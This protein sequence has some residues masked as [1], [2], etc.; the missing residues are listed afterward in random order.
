MLSGF[1]SSKAS[2]ASTTSGVFELI[3]WAFSHE[4]EIDKVSMELWTID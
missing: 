3:A 2:V 4:I 1:G